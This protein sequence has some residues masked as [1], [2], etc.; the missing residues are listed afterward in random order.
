M[1][2]TEN[3]LDLLLD[4]LL[5]YEEVCHAESA[6]ACNDGDESDCARWEATGD[7]TTALYERVGRA[8]DAVRGLQ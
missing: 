2:L 8:L 1:N 5:T 4:A 3:D 6:E 7:R